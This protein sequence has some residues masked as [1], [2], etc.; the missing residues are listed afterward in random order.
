M[1]IE[2]QFP[3]VAAGLKE[4]MVDGNLEPVER[5]YSSP[6]STCLYPQCPAAIFFA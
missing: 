4:A 3:V 2:Q 6:Q 1:M 5:A